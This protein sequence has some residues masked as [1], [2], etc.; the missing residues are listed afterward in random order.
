[1][2]STFLSPYVLSN[3]LRLS[4]GRAKYSCRA[5]QGVTEV[6]Y[7]ECYPLQKD[8]NLLEAILVFDIESYIFVDE[9]CW[10]LTVF[11]LTYLTI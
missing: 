11:Y 9:E 7:T 3:T 1:M 8:T 2:A 5:A 6:L 4:V 10:Y